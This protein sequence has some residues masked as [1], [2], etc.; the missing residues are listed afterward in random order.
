[1]AGRSIRAGGLETRETGIA[2]DPHLLP[3]WTEMTFPM[4]WRGRLLRLH[5]EAD[6]KQIEIAIEAGD[7]LTVEIRDGPACLA[8]AGRRYVLRA[9]RSGWG[10]WQEFVG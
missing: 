1:M 2:V 10:E 5:F 6:P 9:E 8:R 7:D 4:Q 3:G